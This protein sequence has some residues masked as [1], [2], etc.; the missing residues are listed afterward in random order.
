MQE[1]RIETLGGLR[2]ELGGEVLAGLASRKAE[3]LLVYLAYGGHNYDREWLAELLWDELSP[4]RGRANLSVLLSSLRRALG[5]RLQSN[6]LSVGLHPEAGL[7]LDVR[8]FESELAVLPLPPDAGDLSEAAVERLAAALQLYRGDFLQG[9]NISNGSGFETWMRSEQERLRRLALAARQQLAGA[10]QIQG[11]PAAAIE[12]AELALRHDPLQEWP[13]FLLVELLSAIGRRAAALEAYERY[14]QTLSEELGIEPAESLTAL[15]ARLRAGAG[16]VVPFVGHRP[17]MPNAPPAGLLCG[18]E[19]ELARA[20]SLLREPG[21][22]LL[23][24]TG[25]GGIGKT[26]LAVQIAHQHAE[27]RADGGF[28][29][30]LAG[31][32]DQAALLG[33]LVA[34]LGLR[35]DGRSDLLK[36]VLAYLQ[37]RE[38][39]LLFDNL[40]QLSVAGA[41]IAEILAGAPRVQVLATSRRPVNLHAEWIL[42]ISGLACPPEDASAEQVADAEAVQLFVE[43]ARRRLP[44]FRLDNRSLPLIGRMCRL[45][46]GSPLAIELAATWARRLAIAEI[47]TAVEANLDFLAAD[48]PDLPERHRSI[49]AVFEHSWNLLTPDERWAL[50]RLS[51][52]RGG[53]DLAAARQLLGAG[54]TMVLLAT[55]SDASLIRRADD[56]RYLLHELV[57]QYAAEHL[58]ANPAE[59]VA[60]TAAHSA[61]V[62]QL[63][64]EIAARL[65][66][67]E[68]ARALATFE[69]EIDNIRAAW[70]RAVA[71]A[72]W[73]ALE[74]MHDGFT[75]GMDARGHFEEAFD[76]L[77]RAIL[78]LEAH[79]APE[80][81]PVLSRLLAA[82]GAYC[83]R[84]GRYAE[85][86][87]LL[88]QALRLSGG[89]QATQDRAR[90]LATLG[91]IAERRG[92]FHS[93]IRLH[94]QSLAYAR[95]A[96]D[97]S[98]E[99][100]AYY[101]LASAYEGLA[102]YPAVRRLLQASLRLRRA[103]GELRGVAHGLNLL[104]IAAEMQGA[105]DEARGYYQ[106]SLALMSGLGNHWERA[107]PLSNLGDVCVTLGE[108]EA[109]RIHYAEALELA[110]RSWSVPNMLTFLV[111]L[112]QLLHQSR[113]PEAAAELLGPALTN[114]GTDAHFREQARQLLHE[115][116]VIVPAD[117]LSAA[118]VRGQ[119]RALGAA[120]EQAMAM[121]L[122]RQAAGA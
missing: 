102:D 31:A 100:A 28:F 103:A 36:Q 108:L 112:A 111:K 118:L 54:Q 56:G 90:I 120:V 86:M 65:G 73:P 87:R 81:G 17:G 104:G 7:W 117:Q 9:F 15:A 14:R 68:Q 29:V 80:A 63:L 12:Q 105:Y 113:A 74:C 30:G 44:G 101:N 57:A 8:R 119:S 38:V 27:T 97:T 106:E 69:R 64:T 84:L 72:D 40:E 4:T 32:E 47:V 26:R 41:V 91:R 48:L 71:R 39:L 94:R 3:A 16:P 61:Y 85:G 53:L 58:A 114:P 122:G 11:R 46:D 35:S 2:I 22:R 21:C 19:Q 109:A 116:S 5:P 20:T 96:G 43:L 115:L 88:R 1:L 37:E 78:V 75:R 82:R 45:L 70:D 59:A 34:A 18:R 83:E 67:T 107:L 62:C 49:R 52:F 76:R 93:S 92:R 95:A 10:Y 60:A 33:S 77:Q 6:R 51:V 42:P 25:P 121:A 23:T 50:G 66:G 13:H 99:A 98:A 79:P 24:L 89:A 110:Y 55:L